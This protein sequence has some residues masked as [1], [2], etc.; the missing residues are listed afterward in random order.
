MI[1]SWRF[2]VLTKA[3]ITS[4]L[5]RH[6]CRKLE[7]SSHSDEQLHFATELENTRSWCIGVMSL[8]TMLF[9]D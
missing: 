4:R 2:D 9:K 8:G 6:T 1:W 5:I 3:G 7:E